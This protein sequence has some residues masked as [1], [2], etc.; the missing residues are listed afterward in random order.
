MSSYTKLFSSLVT[1]TIWME[2][3]RTRI[4]WIT[5]LALADKNGEVQASIPGLARVAGV[6]LEDC[7]AAIQKFLSPDPYSRTPDDEGRRIEKIDGG[8]ALINHAKYR[9]MASRDDE[10]SAHA[11][12]QR[13]Y[14]AKKN[15]NAVTPADGSVTVRDAKMTVDDAQVTPA[16]GSVT[17]T[18]H[19]AEA[20]T[21]ADKKPPIAPQGGRV[22]EQSQESLNLTAEAEAK[23]PVKGPLQ[24]RAEAIMRRRPTTPLSD[25]ERRAFTKAKPNIEATV[26]ADWQ[27]LE[28]YY[29]APIDQDDDIRRRDLAQLLNNWNGEI[30]RARQWGE[31]NKPAG[32]AVVPQS[33]P[34]EPVGWR[35]WVAANWPKCDYAPGQPRDGAAWSSIPAIDARA[36]EQAMKKAA[37]A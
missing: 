28:A 27:I 6:P 36:I 26:E 31:K 5:M 17:Q 3:D 25:A 18:V 2:T 9:A 23:K 20:D 22:G 11:E 16:D 7:E 34:S 32:N 14:I 33:F 24:L 10:K 35:A 37:A 30:D 8:W 12:R 21:E 15:R 13:R 29:R 19:I 4:V 1:S